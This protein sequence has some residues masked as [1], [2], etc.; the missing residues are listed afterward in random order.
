MNRKQISCQHGMGAHLR[1][2]LGAGEKYACGA[3]Q[4]N[5][6]LSAAGS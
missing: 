6:V 1:G 5:L 2:L 3:S 4:F